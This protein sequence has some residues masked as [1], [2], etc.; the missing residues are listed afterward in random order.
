[1]HYHVTRYQ[2][3]MKYP[4]SPINHTE[5]IPGCSQMGVFLAWYYMP[6]GLMEI[7][8]H[9]HTLLTWHMATKLSI[10]TD[11]KTHAIFP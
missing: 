1:M 10:K 4:P 11:P 8:A 7:L 9:W 2:F 3:L 6:N 5:K